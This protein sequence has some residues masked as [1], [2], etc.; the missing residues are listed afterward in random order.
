MAQIKAFACPVPLKLMMSS[1]GTCVWI[2]CIYTYTHT[3]THTRALKSQSFSRDQNTLRCV[4]REDVLVGVQCSIKT[5]RSIC[6][7]KVSD[8]TSFS[9]RTR[10]ISSYPWKACRNTVSHV[11]LRKSWKRKPIDVIIFICKVKPS[12]CI[13][14]FKVKPSL[15]AQHSETDTLST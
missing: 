11:S 15:C 10:I 12:H 8:R 2:A 7:V 4:S 9:S 6:E 5:S 13:Q 3:H 14:S 1:T